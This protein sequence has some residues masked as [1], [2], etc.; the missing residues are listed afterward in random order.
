METPL[1][2]ITVDELKQCPE[3][4][5]LNDDSLQNM[6]DTIIEL[7]KIIANVHLNQKENDIFENDLPFQT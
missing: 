4:A 3:F 5:H 1:S 7:S 6:L 2:H